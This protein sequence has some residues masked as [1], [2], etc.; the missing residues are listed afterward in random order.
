MLMMTTFVGATRGQ[1]PTSGVDLGSGPASDQ[2]TWLL[3]ATNT[4]ASDLTEDE[5]EQHFEADF[6]ASVPAEQIVATTRQLADSAA[7]LTVDIVIQRT[8]ESIRVRVHGRDGTP[9]VISLAID[10]GSG[11]IAGLIIEPGG[12]EAGTDASPMASPVTSPSASP[13]AAVPPPE[14]GDVLP[15]YEAEVESLRADGRAAVS[16]LLKGDGK[17][18]LALGSPALMSALSPDQLVQTV[19]GLQANQLHFAYTDV[20]AVWNGTFTPTSIEGFFQQLGALDAFSLTPDAAQSGDAPTGRWSGRLQSIGLEFAVTFTGGDGDLAATLDIPSQNIADQPLS[21]V[22][23]AKE[24]PIGDRVTERVLPLGSTSLYTDVRQWGEDRVQI[25]LAIDADGKIASV[26]IQPV[27]ELLPDPAAGYESP[28]TYRLP[29]AGTWFV[30]WGGET[31]L[32]NYHAVTPGQR[33]AYDLLIWK[34]GSTHQGDGTRN[35]QY[36]VWGQQVLAPA[37]GKVVAVLNDQPDQE[38]G[39]PLS[40]SN[41]AAFDKLHPAGNHVVLQT[42]E[43]EFVFLAHMQKGSVRVAVG[44]TVRSG[45]VLGLVGDSGNTSEPHLHIHVQNSANFYAPNAVGLPLAFDDINV[46]GTPVARAEPVQSDF[47]APRQ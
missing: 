3:D 20:G 15:E 42:A 31:V 7:P 5:I 36:Y 40:Q 11:K 13:A 27:V 41:P 33:H 32:Q 45:D 9:L 8:D 44:D 30:Y 39:V 38:P 19:S 28:V 21:D 26:Q 12:A 4:G 17:G 24:K 37:D 1:T 35:D 43:G 34:D 25:D 2:L 14:I 10:S 22:R 29:F 47:I 46:N 16:L 18:F 6:L 23:L